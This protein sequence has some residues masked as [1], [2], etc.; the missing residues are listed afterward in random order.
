MGLTYSRA[1]QSSL[2][3]AW[4]MGKKQT[5]VKQKQISETEEL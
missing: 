5:D 1:V 3:T 4:M 2:L